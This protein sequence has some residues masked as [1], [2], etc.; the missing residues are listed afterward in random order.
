MYVLFISLFITDCIF[1]EVMSLC[2]EEE[3]IFL[4]KYI[5]EDVLYY[6][7]GIGQRQGHHFTGGRST[8]PHNVVLH[9][10]LQ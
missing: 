10:V 8:R 4:G 2:F 1:N 3:A 5:F 7:T 6:E 9:N